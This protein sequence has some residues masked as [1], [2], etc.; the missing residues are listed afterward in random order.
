MKNLER[1]ARLSQRNQEAKNQNAKVLL[2]QMPE[3]AKSITYKMENLR[4]R[5]ESNGVDG[6]TIANV[7]Y[8][9]QEMQQQL[10]WILEQT[11]RSEGAK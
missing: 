7:S 1:R 10:E 9:I 6:N 2:E 4:K 11:L 8:H 5:I 3:T